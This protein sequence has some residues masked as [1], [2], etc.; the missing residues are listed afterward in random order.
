MVHG[1]SGIPPPSPGVFLYSPQASFFYIVHSPA[2]S[3]VSCTSG[4]Q[5]PFPG[6][7]Q[8]FK[9]HDFPK[10]FQGFET[11]KPK[12]FRRASRAG[13][14]SFSLC[15]TS[16]LDPKTPK[17]FRRASRAGNLHFPKVFKGFRAI[18]WCVVSAG[19]LRPGSSRARALELLSVR[20]K[21]FLF[22]LGSGKLIAWS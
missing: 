2:G 13:N 19:K 5:I 21:L 6:L 20:N 18:V 22:I 14:A 10:D 11:P 9:R 4:H 15:F 3:S 12:I 8:P 1:L 7:A 16:F 17:I